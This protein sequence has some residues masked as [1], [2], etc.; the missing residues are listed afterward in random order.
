MTIHLIFSPVNRDGFGELSTDLCKRLAHKTFASR[1]VHKGNR[2][3]ILQ[4]LW[5][6]RPAVSVCS[7]AMLLAPHENTWKAGGR[8][9]ACGGSVSL[10]M[11]GTAYLRQTLSKFGA[12]GW[13][14]C[15]F[16]WLV[17][18]ERGLMKRA[19]LCESL[20]SCAISCLLSAVT[21]GFASAPLAVI[22]PQNL[23]IA[24]WKTKLPSLLPLPTAYE[25]EKYHAQLVR[26]SG[27]LISRNITSLTKLFPHF[28]ATSLLA[29]LLRH[30][31]TIHPTYTL[32]ALFMNSNT[33]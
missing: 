21:S 28:N 2:T 9:A 31:R 15:G 20:P 32:T 7:S 1:K 27:R 13:G 8:A 12:P 33:K 4:S 6:T 25:R 5:V 19:P 14:W 30:C 26:T 23:P 11:D 16:C 29:L 10:P 24:A 18:C 22:T 3:F 17:L